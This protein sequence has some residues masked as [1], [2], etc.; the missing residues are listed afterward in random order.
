MDTEIESSYQDAQKQEDQPITSPSFATIAGLHADGASLIFDGETEAS[1]KHYR[2]N[3]YCKFEVGQRVYI[4]KDNGTYVILFPV[5]VPNSETISVDSTKTAESASSADKATSATS[6]AKLSSSRKISL[7]G[8]L[9]GSTNFD[10]SEDVTI[11]ASL[12]SSATIGTATNFTG[13]HMGNSIGFF[14]S[15]AYKKQSVKTMTTTA[16]VGNL[17]TKLNELIGALNTYGLV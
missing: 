4:A 1:E 15:A 3:L 7:G 8:A 16:T 2:A 6:A 11:T 5:G 17:K 9:S 13:R 14:K 12:S 10:G